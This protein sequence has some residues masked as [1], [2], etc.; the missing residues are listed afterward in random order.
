MEGIRVKARP[1]FV[2]TPDA[3]VLTVNTTMTSPPEAALG[4]TPELDEA[5]GAIGRPGT[6]G[7]VM[8]L[9][10]GWST[11]LQAIGEEPIRVR[12]IGADVAV[13]DWVVPSDDGEKVDA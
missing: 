12:N 9:D 10:R 4:W 1:V 8:R 5:W 13:G 6:P 7:R 2:L 3:E 11:V